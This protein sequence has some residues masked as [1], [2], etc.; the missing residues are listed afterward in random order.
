M[1]RQKLNEKLTV[2]RFQIHVTDYLYHHNESMEAIF[3]LPVVYKQI[4]IEV[5]SLNIDGVKALRGKINV[6][7]ENISCL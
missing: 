6:T 1:Q 4:W 2:A 3:Q 7:S 5:L